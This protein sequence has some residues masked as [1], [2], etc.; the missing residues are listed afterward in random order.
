M[1]DA[2]EMMERYMSEEE[3]RKAKLKAER[4][5]FSIKLARIRELQEL[6]QS[7]IANFSQSSVSRLEKRKDI[8]LSTLIDYI[9]SIGM[10]LEI[11]IYPKLTNSKVKEEVLL[12]T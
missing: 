5:N 3:V 10:G 11:K 8:K 7:E 4:E 2:F 6:T 9:D 1:K 12:R